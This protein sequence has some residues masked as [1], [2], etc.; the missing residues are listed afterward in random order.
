L[1]Y[2]GNDKE[3]REVMEKALQTYPLRFL[4]YRFGWAVEKIVGSSALGVR[5]NQV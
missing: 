2:A 1:A 4:F 3:I 5:R